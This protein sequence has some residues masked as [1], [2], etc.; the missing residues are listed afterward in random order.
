[1]KEGIKKER[2]LRVNIRGN[3]KWERKKQKGKRPKRGI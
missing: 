2:K 1:M 3:K